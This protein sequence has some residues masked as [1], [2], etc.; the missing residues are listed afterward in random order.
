M[1]INGQISITRFHLKSSTYLFLLAA[2]CAWQPF[3][4]GASQLPAVANQLMM[5]FKI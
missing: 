3:P 1:R 2:A 5:Q 4:K